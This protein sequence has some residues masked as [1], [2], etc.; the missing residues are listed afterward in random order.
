MSFIRMC[1]LGLTDK[2]AKAI[3]DANEKII[4]EEAS[5]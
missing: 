3:R 5:E 4:P 1:I 2:V